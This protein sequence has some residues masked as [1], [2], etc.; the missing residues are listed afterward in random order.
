M[1]TTTPELV[2]VNPGSRARIY[3]SLGATLT[4]VE[5][6]VWAGLIATFVRKKG[7]SVAIVDAEGEELTP[8]QAAARVIALNPKLV[9]VVVYG[10]QPSASTQN[11][12]GASAVAKAIKNLGAPAVGGDPQPVERL[13][14]VGTGLLP[15]VEL[16]EPNQPTRMA[17]LYACRRLFSPENPL[18]C[19]EPLLLAHLRVAALIDPRWSQQLRQRSEIDATIARL[20]GQG[21]RRTQPTKDAGWGLVASIEIP[22]G[23]SLGIYEPR[24]PTAI[25]PG[26]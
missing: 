4:A 17:H 7:Y 9:A 21:A 8:E 24:H 14:K 1:T 16:R 6:P 13:I 25:A 5:N 23:V 15:A 3:Q 10:H 2:L 11:M 20:E 19:R 22:G 18:A 12:T 26:A